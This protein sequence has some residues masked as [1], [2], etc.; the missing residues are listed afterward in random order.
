M[1]AFIWNLWNF[2][3]FF[4]SFY[5]SIVEIPFY[6]DDNATIWR[7]LRELKDEWSGVDDTKASSMLLWQHR[8]MVAH[9]NNATRLLELTCVQGFYIHMDDY[10]LPGK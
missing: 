1:C 3:V 2:K 9:E 8:L 10:I 7:H 4:F 5:F 6:Q